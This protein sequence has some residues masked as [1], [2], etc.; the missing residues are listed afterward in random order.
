M[1]SL[2]KEKRVSHV[3]LKY[4]ILELSI[5]TVVPQKTNFVK[6]RGKPA[7]EFEAYVLKLVIVHHSTSFLYK[8]RLHRSRN[9]LSMEVVPLTYKL[10]HYIVRNASSSVTVSKHY[11][12]QRGAITTG[13]RD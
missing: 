2:L 9:D 6:G 5:L 8:F 3:T 1:Y 7:T 13:S 12:G 4:L 11:M 10:L